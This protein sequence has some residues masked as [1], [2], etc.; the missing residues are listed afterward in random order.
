MRIRKTIPPSAAPIA[1]I[2][3]AR[4]FAA[5]IT[6]RK[7]RFKRETEIKQYFGV[8]HVWSVSSGKAALTLVLLALKSL[9]ERKRVVIPAYTCFSVPSAIVKAGLEVALCDVDPVT[10]D[11]DLNCL[12]SKIDENTLCVVPN[13]L[14][15]IPSNLAP[16]VSLCETYGAYVVEDAAQ[17]MGGVYNGRKLG[18]IGH[19]GFFSFGRGKNLTCGS[20][21]IL[22][23]NSGE[24]AQAIEPLYAQL[25]T[26][27]LLK[28][29]QELFQLV[30]LAI[31]IHPALYWLPNGLA[32]LKLGETFFHKDFPLEKL[33]EIKAACLSN[34]LSHLK[35]TNRIRSENAA[36]FH[37]FLR[38]KN[39]SLAP[40]ISYLRFPLVTDSRTARDHLY[41]LGRARGLGFSAM[42]PTPINEIEE[43]S[44]YFDGQVYSAAKELS[45]R[46][47][48]IPTHH[49]L[50]ER[51]RAAVCAV[52]QPSREDRCVSDVSR[53]TV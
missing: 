35:T 14:F 8:R 45:E 38:Q 2:N 46:L 15:G 33:S 48:T 19:A 24:I 43:I 27:G 20:G 32:F 23:S 30:L 21:G 51:D 36:C 18:T 29:L 13:H 9:S 16:I 26:P 37:E 42:Y 44:G 17:A 12:R 39:V 49:L 11:F 47:L 53:A 31:F 4:G 28:N 7:H 41:A 50:T 22:V 3:L 40:A 10:F 1:A 52:F 6:R 25:G 5:L 34:W